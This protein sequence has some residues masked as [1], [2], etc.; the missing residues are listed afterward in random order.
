MFVR[1]VAA[2]VALVFVN[3]CSSPTTLPGNALVE[4][5]TPAGSARIVDVDVKLAEDFSRT[6]VRNNGVSDERF[7]G[8][9][10]TE[11]AESMSN[12]NPQG[13]IPARA[14]VEITDMSFSSSTLSARTTLY[15]VQ[16]GQQ[17]GEQVETTT[18]RPVGPTIYGTY[19]NYVPHRSYLRLGEY[20]AGDISA[21]LFGHDD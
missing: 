3:A 5:S 14:I 11:I 6:P 17:I 15:S 16:T 9:M 19:N 18:K 21:E 20:V 12:A 1:S 13:D 2:I 10:Q 4:T 8:Q 7:R